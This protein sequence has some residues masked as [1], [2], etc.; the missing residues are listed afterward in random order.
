MKLSRSNL[1]WVGI[2][3]IVAVLCVFAIFFAQNNNGETVCIYVEGELFKE[4][5]LSDDGEYVV[6]TS[7]G[8]NIVEIKD[9]K[10]RVKSAD[11][12]NQI[13]VETGW[14]SGEGLP[15]ICSPHK[16]T[17]EIVGKSENDLDI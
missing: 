12:K 2:F 4:I 8:E 11:C 14:I 1:F 9:K 15:I 3:L 7:Y 17:V 13:C 5:P 16:L 6:S 10:V